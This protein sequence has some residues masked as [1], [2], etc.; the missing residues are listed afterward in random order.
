VGP[1]LPRGFGLRL[2]SPGVIAAAFALNAE[3][4]NAG[5]S[6]TILAIV[7]AASIGS[8]LLAMITSR[9]EPPA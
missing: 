9:S 4:V 7:V 5:P 2:L 6:G 8:D 1:E 3:L